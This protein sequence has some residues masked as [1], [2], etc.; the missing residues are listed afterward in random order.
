MQ[1]DVIGCNIGKRL[2]QGAI[3]IISDVEF[4]AFTNDCPGSRKR[5]CC[6]ID[7]YDVCPR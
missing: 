2:L 4:T 1:K 6:D 5:R 3:V 7:I